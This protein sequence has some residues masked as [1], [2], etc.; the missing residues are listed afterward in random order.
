[1]MTICAFCNESEKDDCL[2]KVPISRD[3]KLK[4]PLPGG[5]TPPYE[6]DRGVLPKS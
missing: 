5:G 3:I 2:H 1:M 6:K 4:A